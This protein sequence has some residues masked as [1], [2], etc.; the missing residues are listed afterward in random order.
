M[1]NVNFDPE[2]TL[3]YRFA[4]D[5]KIDDA[6][7]DLAKKAKVSIDHLLTSAIIEYLVNHSDEND[8]DIDLPF[9]DPGY[10]IPAE[11]VFWDH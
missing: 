7:S 4:V 9:G 2:N 11:E 3:I 5:V 6:L 10:E 8:K 1:E